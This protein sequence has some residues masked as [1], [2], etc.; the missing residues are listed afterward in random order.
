MVKGLWYQVK[1]DAKGNVIS[2]EPASSALSTVKKEYITS[3]GDI[4]TAVN[5]ND[6]V[7]RWSRPRLS[8]TLWTRS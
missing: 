6:T 3:F 2:V 8:I 5:D 7:W 1:Y 4:E